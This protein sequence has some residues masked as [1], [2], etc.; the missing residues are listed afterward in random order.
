MGDEGLN[1]HETA[2]S[3]KRS[4]SLIPE[5]TGQK[6]FTPL[7]CGTVH[8]TDSSSSSSAFSSMTKKKKMLTRADAFQL[9]RESCAQI[10]ATVYRWSSNSFSTF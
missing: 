6:C 9:S 5:K 4:E 7:S 1:R 2:G 3:K 8:E 10:L